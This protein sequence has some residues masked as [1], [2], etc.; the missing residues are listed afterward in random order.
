MSEK[1]AVSKVNYWA[2]KLGITDPVL[3]WSTGIVTL[4]AVVYGA[5]FPKAFDGFLSR[6]QQGITRNFSWYFL[7]SVAIYLGVCIVVAF[8]KYGDLKLGKDDEKPHFS[9]FAWIAMLFSCGVGVGY[10]FWAVGEPIMHYMKT[11]ANLRPD[12]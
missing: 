2:K 12:R 5:I 1:P 10:A 8:G 9:Y 6:L 3:F 11:G 4:S 7:L